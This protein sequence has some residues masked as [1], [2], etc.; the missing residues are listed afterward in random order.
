[1]LDRLHN[2]SPGVDQN[3]GFEAFGPPRNANGTADPTWGA[4]AVTK[5]SYINQERLTDLHL[6]D[7]NAR[8]YD[9]AN[10][11]FLSPDPIVSN[12]DD[13]QSCSAYAYAHNNP[14]SKQDPTGQDDE[15][16]GFCQAATAIYTGSPLGGWLGTQQL[17]AETPGVVAIPIAPDW[18]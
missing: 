5:R 1:L 3:S 7:L 16:D 9:P 11:H 13:S 8:L 4:N 14:M 17:H 18:L 15:C 6:I 10:A 2:A 12:R